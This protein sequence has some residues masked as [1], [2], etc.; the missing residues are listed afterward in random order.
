MAQLLMPKATAVWLVDNTTLTFDQIAAFTGLHPLEVQAIADG[1]VA[2]GMVG[3]DPVANAQLTR[4]EIERCEKDPDARLELQK[5]D[6]PEPRTRAK[7][8]R[9]TPVTKRGDKPDGVAWLLKHH[10]ELPDAAIQRLIG[11]TKP[12]INAIRERSHWNMSNIKAQNAVQL[13]LCSQADLIDEIARAR[14][15]RPE[16][17]TTEQAVP[18]GGLAFMREEEGDY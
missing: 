6:A 16:E 4:A 11:T 10:P 18:G 17:V 5:R 9:Y 2:Q 14:R 7:G 1:E 8:P 13:G 3:M 12:T 15:V